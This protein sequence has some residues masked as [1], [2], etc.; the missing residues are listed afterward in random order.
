MEREKNTQ[1]KKGDN[2]HSSL[3]GLFPAW[4]EPMTGLFSIRSVDGVP[5]RNPENQLNREGVVAKTPPFY[6]SGV[7]PKIPKWF[8]R[9]GISGWNPSTSYGSNNLGFFLRACLHRTMI[10]K[11]I[12][13]Q[14][15]TFLEESPSRTKTK[16]HRGLYF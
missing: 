5:T 7:N 11:L 8:G 13:A 2:S 12:S 15:T 1:K 10:P 9:Q 4:S 16:T 3:V 6:G 14:K